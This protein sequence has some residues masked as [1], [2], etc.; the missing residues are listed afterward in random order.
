MNKNEKVKL[1][2]YDMNNLN[3]NI[4]IFM[5]IDEIEINGMPIML[6]KLDDYSRRVYDIY[7]TT[8]GARVSNDIPLSNLND[9]I[10]NS[11]NFDIKS[12]EINSEI[13]DAVKS[14]N[15][16]DESKLD[17]EDNVRRDENDLNFKRDIKNTK[18]QLRDKKRRKNKIKTIIITAGCGAFGLIKANEVYEAYQ[19]EQLRLSE[20]DKDSIDLKLVINAVDE[21]GGDIY[22]LNWQEIAAILGVYTENNP[23]NITKSM[24][25][26][27][28]QLFIDKESG[29]VKYL[30]EVVDTLEL[31][32]KQKERIFNY[33]DDL[34]YH[35]YKPERLEEGSPQREFIESIQDG[36]I[37]SYKET[38]ILPSITI[39][40]AIL[41][42]NW[43]NS[44]LTKESNNL[45]GIKADKSWDGEYV[46]FETKEFYSQMIKD[47]FRKYSSRE[48]S[49][50]DHGKFLKENKR[51]EDG[52]V[53]KA[54]TYKQQALALQESGYSTAQDE[55]G[56]KI[57][58]SMLGE[59]IRQYNLQVLDSEVLKTH[60]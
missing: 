6:S 27:V 21:C 29:K 55:N 11:T 59:L 54:K 46:T 58:A 3:D 28:S 56:N 12:N 4:D 33:V 22:Q 47:K 48:E 14:N 52:G 41:E 25:L 42:S 16:F 9:S 26:D 36:A 32:K 40:Q 38:K 13:E 51:Y 30:T 19:A 17:N 44:N 45:F 43:G 34:K 50:I 10:E 1:K 37:K 18:K 57:Y 49:I 20:F 35:G 39:S 53:F 5:P 60:Q 15:N 31:S 23:E 7:D 24:I 8:T 2:D